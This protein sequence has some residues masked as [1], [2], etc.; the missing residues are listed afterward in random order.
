MNAKKYLK[1]LKMIEVRINN[2]KW[3]LCKLESRAESIAAGFSDFNVQSS[4][5]GE[6]SFVRLMPEICDLKGEISKSI[7]EL[8]FLR[9][10]IIE[11]INRLDDPVRAQILFKR[12]VEYKEFDRISD[13]LCYSEQTVRN[14]HGYALSDFERLLTKESRKK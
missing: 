3:E 10:R 14:L 5:S 7:E 4:A 2:L 9:H 11:K 6:P 1:S 12:Y 8:L 13:E